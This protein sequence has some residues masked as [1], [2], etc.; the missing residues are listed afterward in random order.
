MTPRWLHNLNHTLS[1]KSDLQCWKSDPIWQHWWP[2]VSCVDRGSR[3][4]VQRHYNPPR[5][6]CVQRHPRGVSGQSPDLPHSHPSVC[7]SSVWILVWSYS[8]PSPRNAVHPCRLYSGHGWPLVKLWNSFSFSFN[9]MRWIQIW[10]PGLLVIITNGEYTLSYDWSKIVI[11]A[12]NA[13]VHRLT[14]F[15]ISCLCFQ[16]KAARSKVHHH[17]RPKTGHLGINQ[18]GSWQNSGEHFPVSWIQFKS[19]HYHVYLQ[20]PQCV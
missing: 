13:K 11:P 1:L 17:F 10:K 19:F 9:W 5:M 4:R 14:L 7:S 3:G 8:S 16:N 15:T 2:H 6:L 12:H 20:W 18:N